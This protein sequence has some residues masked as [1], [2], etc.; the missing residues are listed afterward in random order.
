MAEAGM[1]RAPDDAAPRRSSSREQCRRQACMTKVSD[2]KAEIKQLQERVE[3]EGEAKATAEALDA[4]RQVAAEKRAAEEAEAA[5]VA[6]GIAK[7]EV[8]EECVRATRSS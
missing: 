3:Q 4:A 5:R 7:K 8:E 6:E 2:L 1:R